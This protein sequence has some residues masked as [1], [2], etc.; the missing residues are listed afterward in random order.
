MIQFDVADFITLLSTFLYTFCSWTPIKLV[1][2]ELLLPLVILGSIAGGFSA[3][4][5][6]S[7]MGLASRRT[8][9]GLWHEITLLLRLTIKGIGLQRLL[10]VTSGQQT[11]TRT[12]T[13]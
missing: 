13:S 2:A 1:V 7:N 4:V 8:I 6:I 5:W 9:D 12:T 10:L 3:Q 11:E